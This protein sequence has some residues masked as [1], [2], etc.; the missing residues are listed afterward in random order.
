MSPRWLVFA[1]AATLV[2]VPALAAEIEDPIPQ[3]IPVR[4]APMQLDTIATGL[5]APNWG[6][7]P[8]GRPHEL[9]VT[10][11]PG[12]LVVV[13]LDDGT[14]RVAA[15]VSAVLASGFEAG[16]LGLAFDPDFADTGRLF[17]YTSQL[18]DGDADFSTMPT[19]VVANHQSV[20]TEWTVEDPQGDEPVV[21]AASGRELLRID[22]PQGNHNAGAL[23]IGPDEFLYIALGDGG[24]RDDEGVG[25]S[26]QGNGQDPTNVLGTILRIDPDGTNGVNGQYGVPGDNPFVG[27]DDALD[28]IWAWGFRNPFRFSFDEATG[29][30]WVGDV[31]QGDLEEV[32]VVV[33]GGN[34]GWPIKEGS[35]DFERNGD[36]PGFATDEPA[37]VPG[38]IDPV[39]EY[40]HDE[41]I[42]ILGG[43]VYRGDDLRHL[44]GHYVF[45]DFLSPAHGA[46]R[47]FLLRP[48][49]QVGEFR[50]RGTDGLDGAQML[51]FGQDAAGEI[52][53]LVRG[54]ALGG[55]AVLRLARSDGTS[56]D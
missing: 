22:Q 30:L 46:G 52:Y 42:A 23:G 39:A 28:E 29:D 5:S 49:G 48:N 18:V 25:H 20:I 6:A 36:E 50:F 19:G 17:T 21:D 13:D 8:P 34:Y 1:A 12:Q 4:G 11:Q 41:G 56:G 31:G 27:D 44:R 37:D 55:G 32:D 35:F 54:G 53:P 24:G 43:F 45:G 16:L 3:P 9:W 40:D 51:G 15:D 33:P 7:A 2:A 10:D 38:L 14:T 26:P 47:L